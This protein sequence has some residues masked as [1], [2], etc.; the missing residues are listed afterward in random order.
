MTLT[1]PSQTI[2]PSNLVLVFHFLTLLKI[3]AENLLQKR[4]SEKKSHNYN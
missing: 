2:T 4:S 3:M 1:F